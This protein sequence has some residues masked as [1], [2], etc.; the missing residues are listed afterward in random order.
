MLQVHVTGAMEEPGLS[1][2]RGHG[3]PRAGKEHGADG[4][5]DGWGFAK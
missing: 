2:G 4:Q 3:G 1:P 5:T